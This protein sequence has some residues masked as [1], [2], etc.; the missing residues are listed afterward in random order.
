[1]TVA[2][3]L[4]AMTRERARLEL[5]VDALGSEA[6]TAPVTAEGWT[7][8]DVLAHCIHWAGQ[9]AFGIGAKLEPP[10]YVRGV[11]GRPDADEW[12]RLAVAHYRPLSLEAVRA[13]L[14]RIVDQVAERTAVHSDEQMLATDAIPWGSGPLWEQIGGETFL[15]WPEHSE[16]MERARIG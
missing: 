15:H 4:E 7:A 3:V 14:G 2:E 1:M 9:I 11:D 8:K 5:A 6:A 13:E 10:P 12:N 16:Q